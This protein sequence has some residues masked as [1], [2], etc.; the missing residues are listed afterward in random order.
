MQIRQI[1]PDFS[2]SAQIQ[3]ADMAELAHQG[4][5]AIICNRPDGE[6]PGQP[7]VDDLREAAQAAGLAFH[8]IPVSGGTFP[9][10]A[11]AA[12]AAVRRG[13]PGRTLAYCRTGNRSITLETLANPN[14]RDA[15][16]LLWMAEAAGYD[17]SGLRD[18]LGH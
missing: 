14:E 2:V 13:T 8:H 4:F 1:G 11:V 15:D 10:P 18:R 7:R 3:P 17:L 12:F 16:E 5:T 9:A 6:E